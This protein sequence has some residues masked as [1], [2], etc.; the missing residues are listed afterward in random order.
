MLLHSCN[1]LHR[2]LRARTRDKETVSC[3]GHHDH[4]EGWH[5]NLYCLSTFDSNSRTCLV[6]AAWR[7]LTEFKVGRVE[8]TQTIHGSDFILNSEEKHEWVC[9]LK[10]VTISSGRILARLSITFSVGNCQNF[11][12]HHNWARRARGLWSSLT[13]LVSILLTR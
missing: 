12:I 6:M 9:I 3:Y 2:V 4:D 8:Y 10:Q 7:N 5:S 13:E 11:V 1:I